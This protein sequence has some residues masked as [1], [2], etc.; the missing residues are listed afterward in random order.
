MVAEGDVVVGEAELPHADGLVKPR[1]VLLLRELLGFGDFLAC[2]IS[3][4]VH[5]ATAGFDFILKQDD[6]HFRDTGL[7][8]TSVVRLNFLASI[9]VGRMTRHLGKVPSDVLET[10]LS[11]LAAH[12]VAR[13]N[14][15]QDGGG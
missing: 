14:P 9:P 1:P 10:L 4:Q 2:G 12:L 15:E 11:N 6:Q 7:R 5:Q 3:T 8:S 13:H